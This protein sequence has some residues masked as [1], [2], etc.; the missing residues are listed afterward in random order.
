MAVWVEWWK[1]RLLRDQ[2][3][4][5]WWEEQ[6]RTAASIEAQDLRYALM[7]KGATARLRELEREAAVIL[8]MFPELEEER[9]KSVIGSL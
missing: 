3:R 1:G 7:L 9:W 2:G 6:E 5:K 4:V 8:G